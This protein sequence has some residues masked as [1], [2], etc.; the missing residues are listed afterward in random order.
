MR[1]GVPRKITLI[2]VPGVTQNDLPLSRALTVIVRPPSTV[3][4][5]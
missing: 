4:V 5:P 3:A 2:P 1:T